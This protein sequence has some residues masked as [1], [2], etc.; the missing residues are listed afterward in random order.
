M[1]ASPHFI[2][3][4]K[5]WARTS[6]NTNIFR[7]QSVISFEDTQY[8]AFYD[9][10]GYAILAKRT[11][12]NSTWTIRKTDL[13]GNVKDAHNVIC[14]T[15]DGAGYLHM[16]WDHHCH[17]LRYCRSVEPGSLELTPRLSMTGEREDRVTYPEFYRLP[18]GNLLFLYR[19]GQSGQG[20]LVMNYYDSPSQTWT[21]IQNNLISGEDAR[22]AYWQTAIDS[23]G[24]IHLSWV[25]RE[26]PDLATN[27]D[28]CYA[29]SADGG[30]TW[31]RSDGTAY[32]LPITM[33]SAEYA[34]RI[35]QNQ[36]LINQ[37]AM[38]ADAQGN[39][40]IITYWRPVSTDVP[41]YHLIYHDGQ[42]WHTQQVSQRTSAFRL[43]GPGSRRIEISRPQIVASGNQAVMLFRDVERGD[44][45]SA[46]VCADLRQAAWTVYDLTE[47]SVGLWE[48]T[49]D[50]ARW[51]E[52]RDLHLFVQHVGQGDGELEEDIPP[53]M[54]GIL[55]WKPPL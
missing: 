55:E 35:P 26:T 20:D 6:V 37:T 39:P 54:A 47:E 11:L 2:P 13:R 48:P 25:W 33:A 23:A 42:Q 16:C 7:K 10:E 12:G 40:Y 28:M 45:V 38:C 4:A 30:H 19:D 17:D 24:T 9:A 46:A 18:D 32:T 1:P 15:V 8:T 44:V 21:Q 52:S 51:E 43:G 14:L 22:N 27:H 5:G 53:Q 29:K 41:Q 49:L 50:P 31:L 3:I 36:E 34:E